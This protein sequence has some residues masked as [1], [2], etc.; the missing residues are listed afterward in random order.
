LQL[1]DT[2]Q[3]M[4]ARNAA[5]E[6]LWP[7]NLPMIVPPLQWAPRQRGGYRFAMRS[8]HALVRGVSKAHAVTLEATEMP[9]V[10]DSVNRIQET[11][12]KINRHVLT[13]VQEIAEHGGNLAGIPS[14]VDDALPRKP[15]DIASNEEAR[16]EWRKKA[17]AVKERNAFRQGKARE[18]INTVNT[19]V[20]VKD[21]AAIFFPCNLDFRGRV[22]P[23]V[24]YL[25]PQGD[26]LSKS[27]LTFADGKPLGEDGA[28]WLATHG[29]NCLGKTPGWREAVEVH[30]R[31]ARAVDRG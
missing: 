28:S 11:A 20:A 10:Y 21:E 31:R 12:W 19:A 26:D 17:H 4:E 2:Q 18:F 9:V 1:K 6:F 5:L 25:S 8:K 15:H 16:K 30:H 27:L 14:T 29:A 22:Y 13:L 3:W 7:V 23:I 24:N